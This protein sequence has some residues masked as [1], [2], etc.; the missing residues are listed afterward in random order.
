M[1]EHE[2]A[3]GEIRAILE[4]V[5]S[6][7][8][9]VAYS[10]V[11]SQVKALHLERDSPLFAQMLDEISRQSNSEG[12][13]MLSA[14]V[15]HKGDDRRPG[16]GFFKLSRELGRDTSDPIVF[17]AVELQRVHDSYAR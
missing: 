14:V 2:E 4:K 7:R 6:D 10:E 9:T 13:G 16:D 8:G 5:A 1:A 12:R 15:V 11:V 3:V 17:H